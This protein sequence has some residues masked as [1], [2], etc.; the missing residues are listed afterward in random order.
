M[1]ELV[2]KA[3]S[4]RTFDHTFKLT[5]ED[6]EDLVELGRLTANAGN[7]QE[8]RYLLVY[9]EDEV[10]RFQKTTRWAGALPDRTFP[11]EG[12]EPTAFIVLCVDEGV[13]NKDNLLTGVDVGIVAQTIVLAAR[14]KEIAACMLGAFDRG[15]CQEIFDL[16]P[17]IFPYLAIALGKG[18][19]EVRLED[20][21]EET[22]YY[23]TEEDIH[24]VPKLT[25]DKLILN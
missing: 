12:H 18:D 23:R 16:D 21:Q 15:Q 9:K 3:R 22:T 6:L 14:E 20:S 24:V 1:K 10:D 25:L 13:R 5:R 19:E 11:P 8:V 2:K 4:Y 7:K 17:G